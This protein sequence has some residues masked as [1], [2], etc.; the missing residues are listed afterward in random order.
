MYGFL[1]IGVKQNAPPRH[2][3]FYAKIA[4]LYFIDWKCHVYSQYQTE[5]ERY[6]QQSFRVRQV[7]IFSANSSHGAILTLY[8]GL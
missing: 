4:S 5:Q 6:K 7:G 2:Y 3:A 1:R 8:D